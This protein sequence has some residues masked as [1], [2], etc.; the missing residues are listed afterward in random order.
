MNLT[1]DKIFKYSS[2]PESFWYLTVTYT[3]EQS[4]LKKLAWMKR[5]LLQLS[6]SFDIKVFNVLTCG[7]VY[8]IFTRLK[9]CKKILASFSPILFLVTSMLRKCSLI[10]QSRSQTELFTAMISFLFFLFSEW[11]RCIWFWFASLVGCS[12]GNFPERWATTIFCF[13]LSSVNC[14]N[15]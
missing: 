12:C 6:C 11:W 15:S 8:L 4:L 5:T 14:C 1:I 10:A 3:W 9:V 2:K 13:Q 7:Y